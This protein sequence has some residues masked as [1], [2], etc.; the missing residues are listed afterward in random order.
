MIG[1]VYG[2]QAIIFLVKREFMLIGW[3]VIYILACVALRSVSRDAQSLLLALLLFLSFPIYSFFLPVYSFWSMDDFSWGNTRVVLGEGKDKKVITSE[4]EH[5]DDSMI[6]LKKFSGESPPSAASDTRR[7][8]L[9]C[10]VLQTTRLRRGNTTRDT[11]AAPSL[12]LTTARDPSR[13]AT[14]SAP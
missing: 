1:A 5:F 4:G 8:L 3:M 11:T 13:S 12:A 14:R 6:P 7:R 9:I 10:L 2:L